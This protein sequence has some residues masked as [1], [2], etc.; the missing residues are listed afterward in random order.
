M[1]AEFSRKFVH[2]CSSLV[3]FGHFGNLSLSKPPLSLS[4]WA[5]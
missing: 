3:F 5:K 4:E 2:S 1:T